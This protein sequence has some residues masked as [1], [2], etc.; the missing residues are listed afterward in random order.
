MPRLRQPP[1]E[2]A[3][4][5]S[6]RFEL[7]EES[8]G[9]NPD[10]PFEQEDGEQPEVIKA[11]V[12][13]EKDAAVELKKQIEALQRA[14]QTQRERADK[15]ERERK[16][17]LEVA[18]AKDAEIE[19]AKGDVVQSRADVINRAIAAETEAA[20]AAEREYI[21]ARA[22]GDAEAE[23][24]AQRR[25][26]RA[27]AN[28]A[29][30]QN[31]KAAI[32]AEIE[33]AKNRP[34]PKPQEEPQGDGL[35]RI[36]LPETAKR[37]LMA[38]PD[39]MT[40][41]RKNAKIQSLHWEIVQDE[42]LEPFSDAYYE[43]MEIHLGMRKAPKAEAEEEEEEPRSAMVSAP[44]SREVPQN[45]GSRSSGTIRLT[46]AQ[47]EAAKMAGITET[48]YAKQL[49]KFQQEKDNGNYGERR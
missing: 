36:N 17:A 11:E 4:K 5:A 23:V 18:R 29:N 34:A 38:H 6:A 37:W 3:P 44:V 43:S 10:A 20:E 19:K 14:E 35:D 46:A 45:N 25:M 47:R 32:E 9:K 42:K 40:D 16:A 30:L 49:V 27:E 15:A 41:N 7:T 21:A 31:G 48:E 1:K 39:Y 13:A 22:N 33:E 12:Q 24:K 2:A 28:L 8:T 26:V